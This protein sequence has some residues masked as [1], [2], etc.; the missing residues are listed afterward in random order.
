ME[1]RT[2]LHMESLSPASL[3]DFQPKQSVNCV[4]NKA[5]WSM[6]SLSQGPSRENHLSYSSSNDAD[7]SVKVINVCCTLHL[8]TDDCFFWLSNGASAHWRKKKKKKISIAFSGIFPSKQTGQSEERN[9]SMLVKE[10]APP[11]PRKAFWQRN[12]FVNVHL[13]AAC[14]ALPSAVD[15]S[16]RQPAICIQTGGRKGKNRFLLSREVTIWV[17]F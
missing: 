6:A 5:G 7:A 8:Q 12:V 16:K 4:I 15:R 3:V 17:H 2:H 13:S 11:M 10:I 9:F 1:L 14:I